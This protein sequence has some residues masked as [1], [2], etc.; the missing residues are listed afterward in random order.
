MKVFIHILI[1]LIPACTFAQE[2]PC[3]LDED[4]HTPPITTQ[5]AVLKSYLYPINLDS[6]VDDAK[7]RIKLGDYRLL[8]IGGFG[9]TYPPL[10]LQKD[11]EILCT[12]GERYIQGTSDAIEGKEHSELISK[13][14]EYATKY[15]EYIIQEYKNGNIKSNNALKGERQKAPPP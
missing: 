9:L 14:T 1:L 12:L 2:T 6:P 15:N 8:G 11:S 5:I 4:N 7:L 10:D 13:F 3:Y